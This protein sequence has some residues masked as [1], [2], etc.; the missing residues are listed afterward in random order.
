MKEFLLKLPQEI[1]DLLHR[2]QEV[3][4]HLEMPV[5]LVGGCVRDLF[6]GAKNLDL[7]IAVEGDGIKFAEE[8]NK[9]S[10]A[11]LIR[12]R[13]FGTATL[14]I[15]HQLKLDIATSRRETYPEPACLPEVSPSN[16][17]DDLKRRD[18]TLNALALSLRRQ[19]FG[20]LIDYFGAV[21]DL[22]QKKIRILHV[23]SFI[24]DPTRI[25]RAVRFE[26]RYSF[27]IEAVT[28]KA[29]KEAVRL[30][31]LQKVQ[32][33]R[34]RDELILMLKE[35]EPI[36]EIR[37]LQALAGFKF[38]SQRLCLNGKVYSFL[39]AIEKEIKGFSLKHPRNR[40]LDRWLMYFMGL[41]N[42]LPVEETRLICRKFAFRKGE[43]KRILALKKI[44]PVFLKKL[45][46]CAERP[47]VVFSLLEPLSYETILLLKAGCRNRYLQ[48]HISEF[49]E[50]YNGTRIHLRGEDLRRL[51]LQPGPRYQKIFAKVLAAKLDGAVKDKAEELTLARKL[52]NSYY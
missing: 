44:S 37:R 31:M 38:I 26:Q 28:L 20:R 39:R 15:R 18:F 7:D 41:V 13:K 51:G 14:V 40:P 16:L 22:K 2:A 23:L 10:K 42:A 11:K 21:D 19:D 30:K 17:K 46:S 6:L 3:A 52:L 29:I 35:K 49:L 34:L 43:E 9:G 45:S 1:K 32:P 12:H 50:L 25:L 33:Q 24:D 8:F 4:L 36:K 48:R 27:K 47:S 5:Y